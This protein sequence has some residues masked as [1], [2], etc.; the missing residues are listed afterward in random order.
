MYWS[1]RD[2]LIVI[3]WINAVFFSVERLLFSTKYA[4]F[5]YPW[6]ELQAMLC[7][8]NAIAVLKIPKLMTNLF[9][10]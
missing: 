5:V 8:L 9:I 3:A 4:V 6:F 1:C 2:L 7:A 10:A